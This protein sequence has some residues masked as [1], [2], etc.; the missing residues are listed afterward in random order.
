[1]QE[2]KGD[3][4]DEEK[5]ELEQR[6][7]D[8]NKYKADYQ[9]INRQIE[10]NAK[11]TQ[12]EAEVAHKAAQQKIK[13]QEDVDYA[14]QKELDSAIAEIQMKDKLT[15]KD[16]W[17]IG[18]LRRKKLESTKAVIEAN[19]EE[20]YSYIKL[21]ELKGDLDDEEKE[22]LEQRKRDFR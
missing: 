15:E 20:T 12:K 9:D 5:E 18:Y 13:D 3:L 14:R 10:L 2:L 8:F 17:N 16:I 22:E 19:A 6:K 4:S 1:M 11:Q 7:R 21:Q